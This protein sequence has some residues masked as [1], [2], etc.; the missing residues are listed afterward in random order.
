MDELTNARQ[1]IFKFIRAHMIFIGLVGKNQ[2][3]ESS[4]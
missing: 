3:N 1:Q 2:Q 4:P